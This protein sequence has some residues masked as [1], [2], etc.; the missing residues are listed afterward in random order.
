MPATPLSFH[1]FPPTCLFSLTWHSLPPTVP[2][3]SLLSRSRPLIRRRGCSLPREPPCLRGLVRGSSTSA[4]GLALLCAAPFPADN[5]VCPPCLP[6]ARPPS[7]P[8]SAISN[9][10][11]QLTE[12]VSQDDAAKTA[13][14]KRQA[15]QKEKGKKGA[16]PVYLY[17]CTGRSTCVPA[18]LFTCIYMY[19]C[20]PCLRAGACRIT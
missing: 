12:A 19:T 14:E 9:P 4:V 13:V 7:I 6:P 3:C 15:L 5:R 11:I 1:P 18:C 8:P 10:D 2:T 16:A 17:T 20:M